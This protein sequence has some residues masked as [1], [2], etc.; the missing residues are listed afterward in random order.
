MEYSIE[1][2]MSDTDCLEEIKDY[3]EESDFLSYNELKKLFRI[4]LIC[5][6]DR[7]LTK[8]AFLQIT[9]DSLDVVC[10]YT[11]YDGNDVVTKSN[12]NEIIMAQVNK[13]CDIYGG[14]KRR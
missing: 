1:E 11:Y 6:Q 5:F 8:E 13:Y 12:E 7:L 9:K 14:V 4:F 2:L 3:I 10:D